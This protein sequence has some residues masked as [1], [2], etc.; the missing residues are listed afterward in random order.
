MTSIHTIHRKSRT[1][2]PGKKIFPW[3]PLDPG[4]PP[5]RVAACGN[6]RTSANAWA[7]V[8][9]AVSVTME[10]ESLSDPII[11]LAYR[12]AHAP[13]RLTSANWDLIAAAAR[14]PGPHAG[15]STVEA[16][17][18]NILQTLDI[19]VLT[20]NTF[21][22]TTGSIRSLFTLPTKHNLPPLNFPAIRVL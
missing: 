22:C 8:S 1:K 7:L 9:V 5:R 21:N 17:K 19:F 16:E 3:N 14:Q 11:A 10:R 4:L 12:H 2:R 13:L 15:L 6:F 18:K 20:A